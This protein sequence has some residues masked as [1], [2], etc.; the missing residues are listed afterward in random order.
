MQI[1]LIFEVYFKLL[2][3]FYA[4]NVEFVVYFKLWAKYLKSVCIM[5]AFYANT[6]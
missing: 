1:V 5:F 3:A 2:F 4:K 6:F